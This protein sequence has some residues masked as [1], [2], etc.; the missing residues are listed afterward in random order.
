VKT[1]EAKLAALNALNSALQK[2]NEQL[3]EDLEYAQEPKTE[4]GG[5]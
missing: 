5:G 2:E 4:S 3:Q 1:Y